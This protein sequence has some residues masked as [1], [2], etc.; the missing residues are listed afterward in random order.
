MHGDMVCNIKIFNSFE[1]HEQDEKKRRFSMT[2]EDRLS[3]VE[4]LRIEGGKF[5]YEYPA[6]LRR[7]IKI[8]RR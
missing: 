2:P 1:P 4:L 6:R 5:L 3:E 7:V 8:T